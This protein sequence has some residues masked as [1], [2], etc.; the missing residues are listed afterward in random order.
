IG[1]GPISCQ[2]FENNLYF[3]MSNSLEVRCLQQFLKN[4]GQDIYP[5]GLITGN[6]LSLTKAAIIR[7][8][9]KHASEILVP[10]GLEKGTGYVGSMTR[11]KINQLIK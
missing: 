1:T 5:E 4:Q 3:G 7:F 6:F 9:E 8:Q 10:L 11:A 2:R